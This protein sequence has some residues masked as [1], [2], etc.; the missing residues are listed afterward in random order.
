MTFDDANDDGIIELSEIVVANGV[1]NSPGDTAVY[2][3]SPTPT[4]EFSLSQTV[5][6]FKGAL[7][8]QGLLDYKGGFKQYNLTEVFRCTATGNNCRGIHDPSASL[9]DQARA[10]ARRLHPRASNWGYLEDGEFLKLREVSVTYSLPNRFAGMFGAQHASL[11]LGGRNLATWTGYTGVDP[12]VNG[13]GQAAF[14]GFG[15][16]DF[17][18]QPQVRTFLLRA[19]FTF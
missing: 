17:L 7:R 13:A 18:T 9:E 12:E 15:V 11:T 1:L 10:V 14:N 5:G 6:L 19:N 3:G 8:I 16:Q 2:A 4:R